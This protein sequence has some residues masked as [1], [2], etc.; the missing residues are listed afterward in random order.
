MRHS[1]ILHEL[2]HAI[3]FWHEQSR[4]DRNEYIN[5]LWDNVPDTHEDNFKIVNQINSLG[6]GYDYNSVMHYNSDAF[7]S[8]RNTIQAKDPTIP[9]GLAV[10]LSELDV[11][12]TNLLYSC[13]KSYW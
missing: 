7:G 3:G 4:P 12:Q 2:G 11:L 9:L 13:S 6:V 1:T 8:G 10:E 5:V